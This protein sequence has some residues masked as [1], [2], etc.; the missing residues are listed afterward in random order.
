MNFQTVPI[1]SIIGM[2]FSLII[3]IGLPIVLLIV[4]LKKN[5]GKAKISSFFI[6]C[7]TF[8][9]FAMILEQL[10]HFIVLSLT[11]GVS[12]SVIKSDP[13]LLGLYGALVA[14]LFEETGRFLAMKFVM[15]KNLTKE[16]ALT[17]GIGHGGIEAIIVVGLLNINNLVLSLMINSGAIE[18]LIAE[19][20]GISASVIGADA[21][22][23]TQ[24]LDF[25]MGGIER[26]TAVILHICLSVF[27]YYAVKHRKPAYLLLAYALH[28]AVNFIAVI[29]A[30][31]LPVLIVE[32]IL[33][34]EVLIVAYFA[35]KLY[36]KDSGAPTLNEE[37]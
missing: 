1:M 13:L 22:L 8:I 12:D 17:Y 14:A 11:G 36:R 32:A 20:P 6:G 23:T 18:K 2:I 29:A 15:K 33:L 5:K 4:A 7:G 27:V 35:I 28:T 3:S 25:F 31:A 16:N 37:N 34:G 24:S 10:F 9:L 19:T 26:I 21:L 30:N